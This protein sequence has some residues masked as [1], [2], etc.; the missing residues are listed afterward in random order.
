MPPT[1]PQLGGSAAQPQSI[2]P[3]PIAATSAPVQSSCAPATISAPTHNAVS[4]ALLTQA[5]AVATT[6][7][8]L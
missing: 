2:P 1:S 4:S 8:F 5:T 7:K 6:G 3:T